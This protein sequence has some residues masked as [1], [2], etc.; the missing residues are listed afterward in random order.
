MCYFLSNPPKYPLPD[1]VLMLSHLRFRVSA[2]AVPN[3]HNFRPAMPT[4]RFRCAQA[5]QKHP[6][7]DAAALASA[8]PKPH[9][10]PP[11]SL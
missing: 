2:S 11:A 8:V 7:R 1:S 3:P 6:P 5:S 4:L 10:L 9:F